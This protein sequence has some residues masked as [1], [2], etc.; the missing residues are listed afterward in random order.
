MENYTYGT[1]RTIAI[2]IDVASSATTEFRPFGRERPDVEERD[3]FE[4]QRD[5]SPQIAVGQHLHS[6][7]GI[8]YQQG[9][10]PIDEMPVAFGEKPPWLSD[11][12]NRLKQRMELCVGWDGHRG[13]PVGIQVGYFAAMV[14]NFLSANRAPKPSIMPLSYG[15]IQFEW[16]RK[17]WD[18]EIEIAAPGRIY[19]WRRKLHTRRELERNIVGGDLSQILEFVAAIRD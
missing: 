6:S 12:L 11:A 3:F 14:L 4:R 8:I 17:G 13:R 1:Q 15:G 2:P 10:N 16:H 7:P 9:S 18:V 5:A 19:A